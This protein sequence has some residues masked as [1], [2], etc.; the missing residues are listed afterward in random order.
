[1]N[2]KIFT[3]ESV[4]EGHPDKICDQI[5]DAILDE[6]LKIDPDSHVACE[7]SITTGVVFVMGEISSHAKINYSEVARNVLREIGYV[8]S[9]MGFDAN[10]CAVL[11]ALDEQSSDIARGVNNSLESTASNDIKDLIG[12]GDQGMVFGYASDE[13][14]E[15]MPLPILLAHKLSKRL[16]YVRKNNIVPNLRPDGKTQVSVEYDNF[17][18]PLR[19]STV[20]VSTQHAPEIPM[21]DLKNYIMKEVILPVIPENLWDSETKVFVNPTGRF[22]IG[23]PCGDSGLTGRKI[24]VDTYGGKGRHGGGAFSGKDP[25]KVDRSGAYMARYIAKNVVAAKLAHQC[26]V[27]I[28]YVIGSAHPVSVCVDTFGTG[29]VSDRIIEQAIK[30]TF[31]MRPAAII[32]QLKLKD[33]RYRDIASYGHFGQMTLGCTWEMTDMSDELLKNTPSLS[34]NIL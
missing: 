28:A 30:A 25:T 18:K 15:L 29:K 7:V 5:A 16:S 20:V 26:E 8:D 27:Q 32:E 17:G 34:H 12:A 3:S 33:M 2:T 4:T 31:D 1:M 9:S 22:V 23:G 13:T 14:S 24:I 10:T 6:L 11:V 21:K 19:V